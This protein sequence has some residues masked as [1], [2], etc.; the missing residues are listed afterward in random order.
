MQVGP[1]PCIAWLRDPHC[2]CNAEIIAAATRFDRRETQWKRGWSQ[3]D[4]GDEVIL[5]I[6]PAWLSIHLPFRKGAVMNSKVSM[7]KSMVVA[8]ALA[9]GVSGIARAD[10]SSMNRFGGDS[11]AYFNMDKPVVNNAPLPRQ[12]G[13]SERDLQALSSESPVWQEP[14]QSAINTFASTNDHRQFASRYRSRN[15][16]HCRP[17]RQCGNSRL[18][19]TPVR[20]RRRM[21]LSL[22]TPTSSEPGRAEREVFHILLPRRAPS[23]N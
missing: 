19:R 22:R 8:V 10:D 12:S 2:T 4:T 13:L 1:Y 6:V 7:M 21:Q 14:N 18:S 3:M 16:R 23:A 11:Y 20:S 5:S 15:C 17:S 9:A